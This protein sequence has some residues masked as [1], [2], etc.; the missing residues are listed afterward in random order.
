[1][2]LLVSSQPIVDVGHG[3]LSP[4]GPVIL[5]GGGR[6]CDAVLNIAIKSGFSEHKGVN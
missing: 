4:G 5:H 3:V 1:M 6:S 2:G